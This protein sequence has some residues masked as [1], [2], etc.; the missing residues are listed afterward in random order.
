VHHVRD[1]TQSEDRSRIRAGSGPHVLAALRNTALNLHRLDGHTN[2]AH[3]QR[4]T[5][6]QA[7]AALEHI[8][9]A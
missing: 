1:V 7:G 6:W 8:N 5:A 4:R 3:A 9:A 2:I